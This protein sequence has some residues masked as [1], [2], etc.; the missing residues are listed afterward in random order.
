M[1]ALIVRRRDARRNRAE[2]PP[3]RIV[4]PEPNLEGTAHSRHSAEVQTFAWLVLLNGAASAVGGV[5][6]LLQARR[7]D[8]G[9]A[10]HGF[11]A[12]SLLGVALLV[13]VPESVHLLHENVGP[14][15]LAGVLTLF[16]A[17]RILIGVEHGHGEEH[18]AAGH[19][20]H[21]G[22]LSLIGFT[23]H[24][25]ADG[26]A[27]GFSGGRVDLGL[28][29][30][31]GVAL[32]EIPA[33]FILA[34]LMIASGVQRIWVGAVVIALSALL[35]GS[36]W[37][38]ESLTSVL[39]PVVAPWGLA[40]SAGMFTFLATSELIPS[41]HAGRRG[42]LTHVLWFVLGIAVAYGARLVGAGHS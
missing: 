24:T 1:V 37:A 39:S 26:I 12:G 2:R 27:L 29:V 8:P 36:A 40:Y 5:W 33:K 21:L 15:V 3:G 13:L 23:V 9:A 28:P 30:F 22:W 10:I 11:A 20:H 31:I 6:P 35:M 7:G 34:R 4:N 32:H 25:V 14:P 38:T 42:R 16:L 41:E 19:S 17:D 18:A